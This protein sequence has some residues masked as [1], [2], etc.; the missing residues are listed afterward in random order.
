MLARFFLGLHRP[1][2]AELARLRPVWREVTARAGVDSAAYTL[3][4]EE[5]SSTAASPATGRIV[6]VTTY[7]L[8]RLPEGQLAAAL[9]HELGHHAGGHAWAG[10][11]AY[12]YSLPAS[13]A[14]HLLRMV[15]ARIRKKSAGSAVLLLLAVTAGALYAVILTHGL[16]L[17]A[18]TAPFL[19]AAV[20][21]SAELRADRFAS[22]LGLEPQLTVLLSNM[23]VPDRNGGRDKGMTSPLTRLLT[24]RP[25][26]R[27]RLHALHRR[28]PP[29]R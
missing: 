11:L 27:T 10:R 28:I 26:Y 1:T 13:L 16:V 23:P 6:G 25:D 14:W 29:A 15:V 20:G 17:L 3:W 21:R 8:E 19:I 24:S 18:L 5:S 4:V 22:S 7:A 12:W 2:P 9:A